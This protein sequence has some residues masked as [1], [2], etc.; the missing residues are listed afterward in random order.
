MYFRNENLY[1]LFSDDYRARCDVEDD[2]CTWVNGGFDIIDGLSPMAIP[3]RDHTTNSIYGHYFQ[4]FKPPKT[5]KSYNITS[6]NFPVQFTYLYSPLILP[7]L[8]LC[9]VSLCKLFIF[10]VNFTCKS[11]TVVNIL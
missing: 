11:I 9:K 10:F 8:E 1:L 5:H 7:S 3:F 4:F 2:S 6:R